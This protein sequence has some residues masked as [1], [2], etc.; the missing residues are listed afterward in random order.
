MIWDEQRYQWLF[1][2]PYDPEYKYYLIMA[3]FQKWDTFLRKKAL[4][5]EV[6]L[7]PRLKKELQSFLHKMEGIMRREQIVDVKEEEEWFLDSNKRDII[8]KYYTLL[9]YLSEKVDAYSNYFQELR[10]KIEMHLKVEEV[11]LISLQKQEGFLILEEPDKEGKLWHIFFYE[12]GMFQW[13]EMPTYHI[14]WMGQKRGFQFSWWR[15]GTKLLK[16]YQLRFPIPP[17]II[18]SCCS[19]EDI[20]LEK[21]QI[22]LVIIRFWQSNSTLFEM[23]GQK[24]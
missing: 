10:Q 8:Q 19:L 14:Y 3:T 1:E 4:F 11:G 6:V 2:P 7:L 15:E 21:T 16:Q 13:Y 5:P 20:P 9:L 24:G 23:K 17:V 18:Y 12:L 22:P